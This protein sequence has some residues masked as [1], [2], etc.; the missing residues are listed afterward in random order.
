MRAVHGF[1]RSSNDSFRTEN[2]PK[3]SR[4]PIQGLQRHGPVGPDEKNEKK[5]RAWEG[6]G[7]AANPRPE[8]PHKMKKKKKRAQKDKEIDV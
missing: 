1:P 8:T 3:L 6:R 7:G 4:E 2:K 5:K